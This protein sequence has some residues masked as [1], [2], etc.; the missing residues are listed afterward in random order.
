MD[1]EQ[2]L[3]EMSVFEKIMQCTQLIS[4]FYRGTKVEDNAA[5]AIGP[6]TQLGLKQEDIYLAGSVNFLSDETGAMLPASELRRI[7]KECMER[8][9]H[10]IPTLFVQD[11]I[12][13]Y[14]TIYPIPLAM[15]ATFNPD[16]MERCAAMAA[17]EAS[18]NGVD[19]A[20]G[21]MVDLARDARWG[22]VAEGF[23]EDPF[24]GAAMAKASVYGYQGRQDKKAKISYEHVGSCMKH[25][26][27]YGAP[28]AGR[29][30]NLV[31]M[32]ELTFRSFYLPNY[33]AAIEAGV[34]AAMSAF[35]AFDGIPVTG[36]KKILKTL[37]R[38]ELH[39]E[40]V[41]MSDYAA[42]TEL[43]TQGVAENEEEAAYLS[44]E[45]T[46]DIEMMT[47]VYAQSVP[48]LLKQGKIKMSQL[49]DAC[50]RVLTVKE[51]LGL[52]DDPYRQ[53]DEQ[54]AKALFLCQEHRHL[55]KE[56]AEESAVLLKNDGILPLPKQ[57]KKVA[58]IG[59]LASNPRILGT[60]RC[61]GQ[62]KDS[63]TMLQGL[64]EKIGANN[65][66]YACGCDIDY[67][68]VDEREIPLAV[69]KAKE[70]DV[71]I[72]CL[73]EDEDDSGESASKTNLA[74]PDIQKKLYRAV[75]AV[76]PNIVLCVFNGRPLVLTEENETARAILDCFFPGSECGHAITDLLFGD[77][78]PS[79]KLPMSFPRN[80]GQCPLYYNHVNTGRPRSDE[81]HRCWNQS[82]YIDSPNT[83]LY[84]FGYGLSY[85]KF[86]Y[87][88]LRFSKKVLRQG[89][90]DALTV[91]CDI[92][93][94]GPCDGKETAQLYLRDLVGSV[95][96]PVRELKGF[97]KVFLRKGETK[98]VSFEIQEDLLA[99]VASDFQK[100]AE[101][102]RFR[103]WIGSSSDVIDGDEF[104][105]NKE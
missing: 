83:P 59:P 26:A 51:R 100:R 96:R 9:P 85:T 93:N 103:V 22:R 37:L 99:F 16:L 7:Q 5:N 94:I 41:V 18:M 74:L 27:G 36:N 105:L 34:S 24:L 43:I 89:K 38:D 78:N 30:Y 50:R 104:V 71:V 1:I 2:L 32:S 14:V 101:P 12:H 81:Y 62:E 97:Q 33:Q 6:Y 73:G 8:S 15:A 70:A 84:P 4:S 90:M 10:H 88:P 65:V 52:F 31:D 28:E 11:V 58:L 80:V 86:A 61:G 35:H 76:N 77:A 64:Q 66:V 87:G 91:S 54:K 19:M 55:A 44:L 47:T 21:P 48:V 79:G 40:G 69:Q 13:G 39:F 95:V 72:L 92:T 67:R 98:T 29:D 63:V 49:D 68:G 82:A 23:G 20:L 60:W 42:C 102:G 53:C 46:C 17:K 3:K 25:F 45:A 57:G 56:A 75:L